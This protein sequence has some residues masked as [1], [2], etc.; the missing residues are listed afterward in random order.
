MVSEFLVRLLG[1]VI[2]SLDLLETKEYYENK[3]INLF[4]S[5]SNTHTHIHTV[6]MLT[7]MPTKPSIT[8]S[9]PRML[10]K[11]LTETS[12]TDGGHYSMR[13][14]L[15]AKGRP[16]PLYY[17]L[18]NSF[19][20]YLSKHPSAMHITC[21]YALHLVEKDMKSLSTLAKY[22]NDPDAISLPDVFLH[23][24]QLVLELSQQYEMLREVTLI[25]MLNDF[26]VPF[27]Q[28]SE[29]VLLHF[30]HFF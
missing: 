18:S 6:Q 23:L 7:I 25:S 14:L 13:N 28:S 4:L 22:C 12:L 30:C 20:N 8:L 10:S 9:F 3:L 11:V 26:W 24:L 17:S 16:R 1:L 5:L 19:I 27:C 21:T 15:S 29:S 2:K